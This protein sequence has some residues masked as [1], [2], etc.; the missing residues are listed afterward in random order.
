M[1]RAA[2]IKSHWQQLFNDVNYIVSANKTRTQQTPEDPH[3][4][5]AEIKVPYRGQTPQFIIHTNGLL[6]FFP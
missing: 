4:T 5:E 1:Q 2:R 3:S 6:M